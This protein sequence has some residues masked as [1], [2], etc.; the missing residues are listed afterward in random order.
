[1]GNSEY[2]T[3]KDLAEVLGVSESLIRKLVMDR[4]IPFVKI[5]SLVRFKI[6]DI[7]SWVEAQQHVKCECDLMKEEKTNKGMGNGF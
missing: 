5:R 2:L 3:V 7:Y 4:Q 6:E 1:M